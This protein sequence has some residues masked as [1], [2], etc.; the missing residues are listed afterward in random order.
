[1]YRRYFFF[2]IF[3]LIA[4]RAQAAE[5]S[6]AAGEPDQNGARKVALEIST[7]EPINALQG[8]I[9]IGKGAEMADVSDAGSIVSFWIERPHFTE[10][11]LSFA[12]IIPGGFSGKATLFNFTYTGDPKKIILDPKSLQALLHDGQGTPSAITIGPL[13]AITGARGV[14]KE[15]TLPP[16]DFTPVI[17]SDPDIYE[18]RTFVSFVARDQGSGVA[19]YE[20]A[21]S[22]QKLSVDDSSLLWRAA[23]SP[24]V[25]EGKGG[26]GYVYVRAIDGAGNIRTV[27]VPPGGEVMSALYKKILI[28]A[29]IGI[30][31]TG[32]FVFLW[33]KRRNAR[34]TVTR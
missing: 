18:G 13:A 6:L 8:S 27:V 16:E 33:R 3:F 23:E 12:G 31:A 2:L 20:V 24:A 15:D 17:S 32:V 10:G 29:I 26:S 34:R 28:L 1:M 21:E 11:K 14:Q 19:H 22:E 5:F 7:T 9:V 4:T 25:L 30:A